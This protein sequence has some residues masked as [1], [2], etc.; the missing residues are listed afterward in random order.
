M[1]QYSPSLNHSVLL[2][3]LKKQ[4]FDKNI[5][6]NFSNYFDNRK[7]T[8]TWNANT[9]K[10]FL[11]PDGVPQ[12]DP[13]SPILSLAFTILFY[14][15]CISLFH[16]MFYDIMSAVG[17]NIEPENSE[18]CHSAARNLALPSKP[19]Y[20]DILYPDIN[21]P[22]YANNT[23][24]NDHFTLS[25]KKFW[26]YLVFFFDPR[27]DFDHHNQLYINKAL[28]TLNAL[29]MLGNSI[30]GFTPSKRK[31]TFTACVWSIASYGLPLWYRKN[32]RG[33][34]NKTKKLAKVLNTGMRWILG[35]FSTT[36]I[37]ALELISGLPPLIAQLNIIIFKYAFRITQSIPFVALHAPPASP[38][39]KSTPHSTCAE[40]SS[41]LRMSN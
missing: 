2:T 38:H 26:R 19:V 6:K 4:G 41:F 20:S 29:R 3:M 7:T 12:G 27:L 13:L 9:S 23:W 16:N 35:A 24:S 34:K 31:Q 33:V 8:Y 25:P 36:P 11:N 10:P 28:S 30:E 17:L 21:L 5:I 1:A 37:P 39:M 14:Y 18:N 32:G 22:I 15:E 40:I